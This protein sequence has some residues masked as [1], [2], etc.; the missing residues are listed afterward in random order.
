MESRHFPPRV[1]NLISGSTGP[2]GSDLDYVLRSFPNHPKALFAMSRLVDMEH[3]QKP[4]GATYTLECYLERATHF[5]PTD[6]IPHLIYGIYLAKNNQDQRALEEY[7]AAERESPYNANVQYNM[8][9]LYFKQKDYD[10]AYQHAKTA[11]DNGFPL[12]ALKHQLEQ[13][14]KWHEPDPAEKNDAGK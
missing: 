6:P 10:K 11:Y 8:G 12:P 4:N 1:E 13:L 9:L 7:Q 5:A 14:G 2:I 3:T